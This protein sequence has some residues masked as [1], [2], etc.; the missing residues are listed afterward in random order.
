MPA[1]TT[2]QKRFAELYDGNGVKTAKEAGYNGNSNVLN[3]I[4]IKN[5]ANPRIR[6]IIDAREGERFDG[7]IADREDRQL[8]W[9]KVMYDD[10]QA[11][12]LR[13]QA[14]QLLGKS[15]ADFVDRQQIDAQI[16]KQSVIMIP[17]LTKDEWEEMFENNLNEKQGDD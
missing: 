6:T 15:Q 11:M 16:N 13:L 8:F 7:K 17:N 9:T 10:S 12:S 5:L 1:L 14:S 3:Q 2:K 4:A